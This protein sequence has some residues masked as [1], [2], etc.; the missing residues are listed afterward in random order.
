[1]E[2]PQTVSAI[3]CTSYDRNEVID[4]VR[5]ATDS[6]GGIESYIRPGSRVLVKPNLLQGCA[7]DRCVTT[8][9]AVV[10]AVCTLLRELDCSV[11]IADSPGGG[12]RYTA[13]NLRSLYQAAGYDRIAKGDGGRAE[14]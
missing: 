3:R 14:L 8:H 9:P 12:I 1:M 4:S 6:L 2:D 13:A 7:P 10:G 11:M 5:K